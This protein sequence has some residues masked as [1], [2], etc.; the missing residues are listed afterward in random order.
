MTILNNTFREYVLKA[1]GINKGS[2]LFLVHNDNKKYPPKYVISLANKCANGE[3]LDIYAFNT[4]EVV[5]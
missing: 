5:T 2:E 3:F 4:Q 1:G